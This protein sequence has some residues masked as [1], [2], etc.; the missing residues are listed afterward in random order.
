M[1]LELI[2]LAFVALGLAAVLL[3]FL[4]RDQ[5]GSL[6]LPGVIDRSVGMWALRRALGR[7]TETASTDAWPEGSG[8]PE[9]T[10]EEIAWRIGASGAPTPTAPTRHIVAAASPP[11]ASAMPAVASAPPS[12][13]DPKPGRRPGTP[14]PPGELVAIATAILEGGRVEARP[15]APPRN[16][17]SVQRRAVAFVALVFIVTSIAAISYSARDLDDGVL[18]ATGTPDRSGPD[19]TLEPSDGRTAEPPGAQA[20]PSPSP[21]PA[22]ATI[23]PATSP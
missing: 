18:S 1:S 11:A 3:R 7:P 4:P 2:V 16:A 9:P 6:R 17:L 22:A 20:N 12:Q 5:G 15:T 10:A 21:T 23:V 8:L 13:A 19:A 14:L